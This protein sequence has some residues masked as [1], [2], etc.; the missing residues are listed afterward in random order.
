MMHFTSVLFPAPF[1]P[2][3]VKSAGFEFQRDL[4]VRDKRAE[5]LRD[6]DELKSRWLSLKETGL[7]KSQQ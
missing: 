4:V 2:S 3:R 7:M 1:S 5:P 6:V